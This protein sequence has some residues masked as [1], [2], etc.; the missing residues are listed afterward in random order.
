MI[1]NASDKTLS[2]ILLNKTFGGN[3]SWHHQVR[4]EVKWL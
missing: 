4:S 1:G 2:E 3:G